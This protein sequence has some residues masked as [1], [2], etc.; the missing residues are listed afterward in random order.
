VFGLLFHLFRAKVMLLS[1]ANIPVLAALIVLGTTGFVVTGTIQVNGDDDDRRVVNL[2]VKPLESKT[3]FDAL[4]AQTETLL[5]LDALASDA[6]GQLRHLRDRARGKANDQNKMIDE[7]ALRTQFDTASAKIPPALA[8]TRKQ[9]LDAAD[10]SKCQDADPN[11]TVSL[12]V[13]ALRQTYDGILA[14]FGQTLNGILAEAQT[15]FDQL[16]ATAQARPPKKDNESED[17]DDDDD[18]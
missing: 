3:C 16:V 13:T 10:L 17:R 11:T 6:T 9:V 7:T 14:A 2:T 15:A 5:E 4:L 18:D 12:N 1:A 8:A